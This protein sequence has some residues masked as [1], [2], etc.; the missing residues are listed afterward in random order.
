MKKK[1]H[2]VLVLTFD[3]GLTRDLIMLVLLRQPSLG[4]LSLGWISDVIVFIVL[5]TR[6]YQRIVQ[7]WGK[8]GTNSINLGTFSNLPCCKSCIIFFVM[9]EDQNNISLMF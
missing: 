3:V 6:S 4:D 8:K 7:D 2:P 9:G 5:A 1:A